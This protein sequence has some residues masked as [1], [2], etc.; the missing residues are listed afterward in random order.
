M[1]VRAF[2]AV[3]LLFGGRVA[4]GDD[5]VYSGPQIGEAITS[6]QLRQVLSDG[7]EIDVVE[8]AK[9]Q[10]VL[11]LFVHEVTRPSI[12]LTRIVAD[13]AATRSADGLHTA[14][15][16]L[17]P[18]ATATETWMKNARHALP[19]KVPL[20][21]SIDGAE[22][23]GAF[24]LNREVSLTV[25]VAKDNKV[26]ANFALVQPSVQ[27]DGPKI[28]EAIVAVLGGG[29]VP[30]IEDLAGSAAMRREGRPRA[31]DADELRSLL[32]PVIQKDGS[33]EQIDKAAAAIDAAIA[34]NKALGNEIGQIAQRIIAAGKLENYGTPRS[35]V[36]LQRWAREF[37]TPEK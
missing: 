17:T 14:V 21:I 5:A 10:P 25:L 29:K 1:F 8:K 15:V 18:D 27:A 6:F 28:L 16:L 30:K 26:T 3:L 24:G 9:G 4:A 22:G 12:G 33:D 34:K 20:G 7:K 32:R 19:Q 11:L 13:Y 35:Q 2:L 37:S 31:I 36:H 23:P